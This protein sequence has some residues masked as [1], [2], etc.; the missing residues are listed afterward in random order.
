MAP[1]YGL[2]E[3]SSFQVEGIGPID[4]PPI[5]IDVGPA[6]G[7]IGGCMPFDQWDADMAVSLLEEAGWAPEGGPIGGFDPLDTGVTGDAAG[8]ASGGDDPGTAPGALA[9]V[10][11]D[12]GAIP[13]PEDDLA[14]VREFLGRF[15][16][17]H[18]EGDVDTLLELLDPLAIARYGEAQCRGYLEAVAGS[19]RE[20]ELLDAR[21]QPYDYPTDDLTVEP[22]EVWNLDMEATVLDTDRQTF[23]FNL[24][25]G[26]P[27]GELTWFTDCGQPI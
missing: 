19:I 21:R 3:S 24:G 16:R 18:Q 8:D 4:G 9:I 26:G 27:D 14:P 1:S 23:N 20:L 25:N 17:A 6:E 5:L 12:E 22:F 11:D 7:P 15:D 2:Y 13:A 10:V